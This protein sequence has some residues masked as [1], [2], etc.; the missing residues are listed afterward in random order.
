MILS[1]TLSTAYPHKNNSG[2]VAWSE[3]LSVTLTVDYDTEE[4]G[5]CIDGLEIYNSRP[6]AD[7]T[8]AMMDLDLF[9]KKPE[10]WFDMVDWREVYRDRIN[11]RYEAA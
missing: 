4:H 3:N 11:S 9:D 1:Y 10:D 8:K 2:I 5:Y 7:I 6:G